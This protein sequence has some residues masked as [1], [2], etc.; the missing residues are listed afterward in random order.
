MDENEMMLK[1]DLDNRRSEEI[2][3]A[4]LNANADIVYTN[5]KGKDYAEVKERIKAFRRV[6]PEGGIATK[7]IELD[8]KHCVVKAEVY[9]ENGSLLATG[10]A[11]E[12]IGGSS[13]NRT[14]ML[15]NCETGAC[16]RALG[17]LGFGI[18]GGVAS[19]LEVQR[20]EKI[21]EKRNQMLVCHRCGRQ[22]IDC[23]DKNG[24]VWSAEE[25]SR[26]TVKVYGDSYCLPCVAEMKALKT[27]A[28]T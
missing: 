27:E 15:E 22:I 11:S 26:Q 23:A 14:S 6:F 20:A 4:I 24:K 18:K 17:M 9:N 1:H 19:A 5:I 28:E 12:T 2:A 8:D 21:S 16:G 3:E 7:I 13:I 25:I 10:H